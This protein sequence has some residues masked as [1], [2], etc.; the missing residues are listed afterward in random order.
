MKKSVHK[1]IGS[2]QKNVS[3]SPA[4][5]ILRDSTTPSSS[6]KAT[7]TYQ[8]GCTTEGDIYVRVAANSGGGFWSAEWVSLQAVQSTLE[9]IPKD[10]P[11]TSYALRG[12]FSGKSVNSRGFLM[13]VLKQL[14]MVKPLHEKQ[15]CYESVD[16]TPF[17]SE[18]KTLIDSDVTLQAAEPSK[19]ATEGKKSASKDTEKIA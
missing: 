9:S 7:L 3:I 1:E 17:L 15:R 14:G 10:T 12:L 5:R 2:K 6:G 8:I 13:A 11:I 16:A 19:H 4:I 18:V